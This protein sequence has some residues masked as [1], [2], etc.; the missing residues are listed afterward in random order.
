[1]VA[2][3]RYQPLDSQKRHQFRLRVHGSCADRDRRGR[4]VFVLYT[5]LGKR[6]DRLAE[7]VIGPLPQASEPMSV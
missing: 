4:A 6:I 3:P 7:S 1:V 2:S 5:P